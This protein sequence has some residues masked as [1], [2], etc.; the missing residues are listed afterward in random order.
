MHQ[1]ACFGD[2]LLSTAKVIFEVHLELTRRA[3]QSAHGAGASTRRSSSAAI[4]AT[5]HRRCGT[6][7]S[8]NPLRRTG[9]K[10][11]VGQRDVALWIM[12]AQRRENAFSDGAPLVLA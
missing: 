10:F 6:G 2:M 3:E 7:G 8:Y 5:V 1:A 9:G 11:G 12:R 4:V